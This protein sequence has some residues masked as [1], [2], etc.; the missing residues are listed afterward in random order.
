MWVGKSKEG[1]RKI[2]EKARQVSPCIIFFDEIDS[3]A[4]R[5]G[6]DNNK[7]TERVLNQMLAEMNGIE[8]T[9]DVLVIAATNRPDM[10]DTALLRPGRFDKILLV[11]APTQEGNYFG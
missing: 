4:G 8:D 11:S 3:I 7:V 6:T 2:F 9:K 5:R 1:A 10:L